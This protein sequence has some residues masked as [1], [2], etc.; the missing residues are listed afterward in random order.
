MIV[1]ITEIQ[2]QGSPQDKQPPRKDLR[3]FSQ[4]CPFGAGGA[5]VPAAMIPSRAV[6]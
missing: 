2:R 6:R 4:Q 5:G 1:T 3:S